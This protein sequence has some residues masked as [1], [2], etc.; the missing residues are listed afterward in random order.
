[1][2]QTLLVVIDEF[3]D[4]GDS[5]GR[6]VPLGGG[7]SK[8]RDQGTFRLN[9]ETANGNGLEIIRMLALIICYRFV[10]FSAEGISYV[11]RNRSCSIIFFPLKIGR[12]FYLTIT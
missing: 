6:L 1:M 10:N 11:Q 12:N 4:V 2:E 7:A 8:R 3:L 9:A 5:Q